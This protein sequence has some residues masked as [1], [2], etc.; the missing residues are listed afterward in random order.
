[1][2]KMKKNVPHTR[3]SYN[4]FRKDVRSAFLSLSLSK[5]GLPN[6]YQIL[7]NTTKNLHRGWLIVS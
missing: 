2:W 6:T 5:S 1:M 4:A 3:H 7:L